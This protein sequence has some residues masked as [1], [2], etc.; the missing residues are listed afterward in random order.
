MNEERYIGRRRFL[1]VTAASGFASLGRVAR[2]DS[3]HSEGLRRVADWIG[4][5]FV[6]QP[7]ELV[8]NLPSGRTFGGRERDDLRRLFWL[9]NCNLFAKVALR[10]YNP[11]LAERIGESYSR[12]YKTAFPGAE[13]RTE[14]YLTIGQAPRT[15]APDGKYFRTVV[16]RHPHGEYTVGTETIDPAWLGTIKDND[17]RGLLKFGALG[18]RV[19][20]D[21]G[22]ASAYFEKALALWDGSGFRH[23][24]MDKHGAYYTRYLAYALIVERALG[25]RIPEPARSEIESRLWTMQDKDGGIWTNYNRDGTVPPFAKKT[26]EIGPLALL[27]YDD[28][29]WA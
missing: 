10:P 3:Q 19:R 7:I 11:T 21:H 15:W 26:S 29:P 1:E 17:P 6:G 13:E 16:K 5:G 24:R 8:S 23:T 20:G 12:W 2:G 9:Q 25:K 14:N 18:S 28:A 4:R 22:K 27:A